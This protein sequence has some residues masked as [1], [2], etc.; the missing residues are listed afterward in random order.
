M[1]DLDKLELEF[2][3]PHCDFYNPYWFKQACLRDVIICRGCKGNI[4]LDD[5]MNECRKVT[6]S[7]RQSLDELE[8]EINKLNITIKV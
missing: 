3:C 6:R 1:I 5:N 8:N 7:I 4:Q 2:Q